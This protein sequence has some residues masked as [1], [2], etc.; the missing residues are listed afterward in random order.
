VA[1]NSFEFRLERM[2]A[3]APALPDAD[4]FVLK[5]LE[6]LDR[7]WAARRL[8]IGVMGVVGGLIGGFEILSTGAVA[9]VAA[10]AARSNDFLSQHVTSALSTQLAPL[11]LY[12]DPR[13]IWYAVAL[14]VVAAGLGVAR[15]VR[16][17]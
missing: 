14:A 17:I 10:L 6:R 2:F 1:D 7:G 11:G 13:I 12:L 9:Q 4:F 8:L 15:L 16:E 3:E 5:V